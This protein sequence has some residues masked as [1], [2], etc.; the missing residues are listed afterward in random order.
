MKHFFGVA[1]LLALSAAAT[2]A[3]AQTVNFAS[4]AHR[5]DTGSKPA[6]A[7]GTDIYAGKWEVQAHEG[8]SGDLWYSSNG[9]GVTTGG[10]PGSGLGPSRQYA[11]GY[12]PAL[13]RWAYDD[14]N[15]LLEVHQANDGVGPLWFMFGALSDAQDTPVSWNPAQ[16]YDYGMHPAV[17]AMGGVAVE[18]HQAG[19]GAGPLWSHVLSFGWT[20]WGVAW[21][22]DAVNYTNGVN[23]A[24]AMTADSYVNVVEVHQANDGFG[25]LWYMTGR[26]SGD[27]K[28]IAWSNAHS[29][30]NG[31]KP[32]IVARGNSVLEVHQGNTGTGTLWYRTGAIQADGTIVW[33]ANAVKYDNGYSPALAIDPNNLARGT[34]G[35]QADDGVGA[36]WSHPFSFQ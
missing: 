29:Y 25:P 4:D 16:Q 18:V 13:T 17:A 31:E 19:P 20:P 30:D 5:F 36:L 12:R 34:D 6:I 24:V 15:N 2:G 23:P 8:G 1:T 3:R 35:H 10:W 21:A 7:L 9:F 28:T 11:N 14:G 32:A 27:A 26:L 33:S 22:P